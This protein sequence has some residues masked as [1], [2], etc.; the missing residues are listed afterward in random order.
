MPVS[1]RVQVAPDPPTTE[2]G[3]NVRLD[4]AAGFSVKLPCTV[5]EPSVAVIVSI[6]TDETAEVVIGND[7]A[8]RSAGT[9]TVA[10]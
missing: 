8:V 7:F 1:V 9:L 2:V 5:E 10:G 3:E 6:F 4:T